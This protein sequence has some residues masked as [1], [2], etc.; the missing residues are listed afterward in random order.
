MKKS[1]KFQRLRG[2]RGE[3]Q[4]EKDD[5][6]TVTLVQKPGPHR[7]GLVPYYAAVNRECSIGEFVRHVLAVRP[8]DWG[9]LVI[10]GRDYGYRFGKLTA[11]IPEDV[12]SGPLRFEEI[13]AA[14]GRSRM[15]W[16]IAPRR[17]ATL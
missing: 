4:A 8:G 3:I 10:A 13:G 11:P 12:L 1:E 17:P 6:L 7:P 5:G 9:F 2:V 14:G 16:F 15:D